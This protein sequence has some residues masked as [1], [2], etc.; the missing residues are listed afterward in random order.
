MIK[1][2]FAAF[3]LILSIFCFG[4]VSVQAA[5]FYDVP[6]DFW[7]APYIS[8]LESRGIISGYGDGYFLPH[9]NVQRRICKN[10]GKCVRA[11]AVQPQNQSVC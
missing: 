6:D 11:S 2:N 10:A 8:N 5:A 4:G 9:N 1:K 3:I 7:A